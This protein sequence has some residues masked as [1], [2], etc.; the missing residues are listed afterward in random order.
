MIVEITSILIIISFL[1]YLF[2]EGNI[3]KIL[4][5]KSPNDLGTLKCDSSFLTD[6]SKG[7]PGDV[8]C[9][10]NFTT[11][12]K[13][14]PVNNEPIYAD[15]NIELCSSKYRCDLQ[16]LPFAVTQDKSTNL[17]GICDAGDTCRCV[18]SPQCAENI[19]SLFVLKNGNPYLPPD[20]Q[21]LSFTQI[22][23]YSTKVGSL[24]NS[25]LIYT[26]PTSQ[27]CT[28]NENLYKNISPGSCVGTL[29]DCINTN[30]CISGILKKLPGNQIGCVNPDV[31]SS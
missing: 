22:N 30:P 4:V 7:S 1:I 25:P 10:I 11:G 24:S 16:K 3:Y 20:T 8:W 17:Q 27:Y 14:C 23:S 6:K 9:A 2:F 12:E 18:A 15:L 19:S 21:S 31:V 29:D 28:I 5:G 26:D 13:R